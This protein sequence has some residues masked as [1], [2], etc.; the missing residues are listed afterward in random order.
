MTHGRVLLLIT[1]G[2]AAYKACFLARLLQQTGFSVR[3]AMTDA[4]QRFVGPVT[5]RALTGHAVATDIWGDGQ[6]E[7]LDHIEYARWADL[8]VVAPAT[9]NLLAKAAGGI[10]DDIVTTLL[11]AS[12]C[13]VLMAPAMNDNMWRHAAT[14]ANRATLD[15]RGVRFV[16]PGSGWLACGTVDEGRMA[17]PEEIVA[18]V[19]E[20]AAELDISGDATDM[21]GPWA[22]R[23]VTVTAGP[24]AE[25]IDPVRSVVNRSSGA[26]GY[27]LAQAAVDAGA[28]VTLISGYVHR[29][30]PRGLAGFV[31]VMTAR[32]MA[33]AVAAA[34]DQGCDWLL[35]AAAV[36]DFRPVATADAKLKK[37]DL[38]DVWTL[39]L[40]RNPDILKDVVP[41]HRGADTT[42]VGFALET[43]DL[44]AMAQAK[45]RAKGLDF[46]LANDP[47][48]KGAGFGDTDH[49]VT[50]LGP[51][52]VLWE[53]ESMPKP[54]LAAHILDRLEAARREGGR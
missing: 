42:V 18:A 44:V 38:G 54:R 31:G 16:G 4:A 24:T 41:G 22:G 10:A 7:A 17:E 47:T 29:N 34:L 33:N 32:D 6:S 27:A 36:A 39:E 13:P 45:L 35:M 3:V 11:L 46:I 53:S 21:A 52:G 23:K 15:E 49:Q 12:P 28:E 8:V 37:D 25:P 20:M 30:P 43:S 14:Q 9:A 40:T 5:L 19:R 2:I 26:M 50:L 1:G 48:A 51:E